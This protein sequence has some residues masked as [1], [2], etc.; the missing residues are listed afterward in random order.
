MGWCVVLSCCVFNLMFA[1]GP[2]PLC[3]FVPGEL[4][5]QKVRA[6]TYTWLNIV[7]NGSRSI[8]LIVYFP[9]QAALGGPLSYFLLFFPPCAIT[10][11]I[12]YF[13]LPETKGLTP[14]EIE[15]FAVKARAAMLRLR[16][17]PEEDIKEEKEG[18][19]KELVS[20]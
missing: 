18:K 19:E 6:A 20:D 3:F 5:S 11:T 10:V 16:G 7:M 13:F 9:I 1:A 2:G 14:E 15:L 8:L 4:V 17:F 12:C